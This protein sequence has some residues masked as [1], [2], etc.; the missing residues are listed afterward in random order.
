MLCL[1]EELIRKSLAN[2]FVERRI[3]N[4][5]TEITK[6]DIFRVLQDRDEFN[7]FLNAGLGKS[8]VT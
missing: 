8:S 3:K 1:A 7:I 4:S 2:N 5:E 6:S